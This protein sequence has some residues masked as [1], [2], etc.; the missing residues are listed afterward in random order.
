MLPLEQAPRMVEAAS[1]V[2]RGT[3]LSTYGENGQLLT[4]LAP[5]FELLMRSV[6]EATQG[7]SQPGT[8]PEP[9]VTG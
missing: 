8:E 9:A 2:L 7:R 6:Q 5:I 1:R 3:N 4:Q